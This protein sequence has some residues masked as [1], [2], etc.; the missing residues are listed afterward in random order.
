MPLKAV[1]LSRGGLA[2]TVLAYLL[3][4]HDPRW[5]PDH[6]ALLPSALRQTLGLANENYALHLLTILDNQQPSYQARHA[7]R[8]L[9]SVFD[10][11]HEVLDPQTVPPLPAAVASSPQARLCTLA[12][13]EAVRLGVAMV[14]AGPCLD[15]SPVW[16]AF[17][18]AFN[19]TAAQAEAALEHPSVR[20]LTPLAGLSLTEVITLGVQLGVPFEA[21]WS[22]EASDGLLQCGRCAPCVTR[23]AALRQAGVPDR[24]CYRMPVGTHGKGW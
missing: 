17:V 15:G 7:V 16:S 11:P 2:S 5:R 14:A 18:A 23:R 20:L 21:T 4:K 6:I 8:L 19:Q 24:T 22:C 1:V 3:G 9:A 12:S 10:A 13:A